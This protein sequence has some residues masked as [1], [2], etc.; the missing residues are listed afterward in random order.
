MAASITRE[1]VVL[2][3]RMKKNI[4]LLAALAGGVAVHADNAYVLTTNSVTLVTSGTNAVVRIVQGTNSVLLPTQGDHTVVQVIQVSN[5]PVLP[6]AYPWVSSVVAGLTLTR[7]NSDTTLFT[8][9]VQTQK[10]RE[11]DE[12]LF[13]ADGSY[14]V[15][16]SVLSADSLHGSGQ[17]NHLFDERM[18]GFANADAL[19]DGIQDLKYRISLSPGA[20][21]Y[22]I[23]TKPTSLVG[24]V[25]PGFVSEL[26]GD[27]DESYLSVRFAEHFDQKLSGTARLWEKA[28]LIPQVTKIDNYFMNAEIGV[29]S[30]LTKRLSLQVT[31]DDNYANEPA[32][33]RKNNDVKL[34]SGVA[35]KF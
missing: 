10:K 33:G 3:Q 31:L 23:K 8:A 34:I 22:F 35:F 20:G 32:A 14:G 24:E 25:G 4:L 9:K 16:N 28:E 29:E 17:Y 18:Y 26:R 5:A 11:P 6:P 13:E 30:A 1:M 7:G 15:N 12:W 27:T 19:H 21:Y 2:R